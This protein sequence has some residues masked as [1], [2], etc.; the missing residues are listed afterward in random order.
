MDKAIAVYD[1]LLKRFPKSA[2]VYQRLAA[3]YA[4]KG[5]AEK[6]REFENKLKEACQYADKGI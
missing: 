3:A 5:D 2:F 4:K 1:A 6:G